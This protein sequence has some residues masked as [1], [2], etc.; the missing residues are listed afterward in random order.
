MEAPDWKKGVGTDYDL[1]VNGNVFNH[2]KNNLANNSYDQVKGQS[3]TPITGNA[4]GTLSTTPLLADEWVGYGDSVDF[5]KL[6]FTNAGSYTFTVSGVSQKVKLTVYSVDANGRLKSMKSITVNAP[7]S[8]VAS[9]TIQNLLMEAGKDYYVAVEAPDWKKGV[10]TDYD[11]TV[12]GNV[13]NH[14]KNNLA[15][16]SYEQVKGQSVTPITGSADGTL[17]STPVLADEWVG[18]GDSVDFQKITLANDGTYSFTVSGVSQKVKLTVY[19]VDA[20]GNLKSLKSITVNAPKSGVAS[21][22][23]Q[24]LLMDAGSYYVA[25]EATDW[26]K[27]VGT[28]YNVSMSGS[29]YNNAK[30]GLNNGSWNAAG[31][32]TLTLSTGKAVSGEWVGYGDASDYFAFKVG[33]DG[34]AAGQYTFKLTSADGNNLNGNATFTIYQKK[35]N[36]KGAASVSKVGSFTNNKADSITL[37]LGEGEYFMAVD[38]ADKGKGKKNMGYDIDVTA[39][40]APSLTS[41]AQDQQPAPAAAFADLAGFDGVTAALNAVAADTLAGFG[42]ALDSLSGGD[43]Q[44]KNPLFSVL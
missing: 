41:F 19:G 9:G 3:V 40:A 36:S 25:V 39:P 38:S 28:D 32:E 33:A 2:A 44:K 5:Q 8:G 26:K 7:K 23:I 14:A 11:L 22:T 20:K 18:Y 29:V 12:N 27:G 21:G 15:N 24:N 6:T 10:G 17:S 34:S 1:T 37:D 30:N 4:D 35:Y 13:F 31:V 42:S 43:E 16:N